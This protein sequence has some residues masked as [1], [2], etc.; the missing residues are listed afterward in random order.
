M[1]GTEADAASL[2]FAGMIWIT[3]LYPDGGQGL[4][5]ETFCCCVGWFMSL[6][7]C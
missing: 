7:S 5:K 3:G 2:W 6:C 4:E 1:N